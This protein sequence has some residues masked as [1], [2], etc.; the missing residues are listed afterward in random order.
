MNLNNLFASAVLSLLGLV[1]SANGGVTFCAWDFNGPKG[2]IAPSV[3]SGT[4]SLVGGCSGNF[5]TG[6]PADTGAPIAAENKGWNLAGFS[7]QGTASGERGASFMCSTVGFTDVH[8]TWHERHSNSASRFV[9]FQYTLDGTAF[10]SDGLA[11]NGIFEA[12]LGGDLWQAERSVDLTSIVGAGNNAKFAF[13]IVS[14]FAPGGSAFLPSNP[15]S[16]YSPTGTIR[17]DL[18]NM[19]GTAV[20]APA[21]LALGGLG[22]V[23]VAKGRRRS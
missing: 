18:V 5:S 23:L 15:T 12:S 14:I 20:P 6:D 10:T 16:N 8:I 2:T 11:N 7:S 19:Q 9:Q 13:R 17:F 21:P 4:A 3:G 1:G 22:A